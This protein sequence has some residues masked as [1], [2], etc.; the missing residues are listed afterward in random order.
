M[1]LRILVPMLIAAYC[2]VAS[3][4]ANACTRCVYLGPNGTVIV[5]RS[6]D[7]MI[8]PGTNLYMFPRGMQRN[9]AAGANSITWTSK[10]GS[11]VCGFYGVAS[12]DGMNERGL[13]ANTL[14]L[15]ES[16]YGKPNDKRP[17]LSIAAWTQYVLDNYAS[18][19]EA[20][21]GLS[22]EPFTIIAPMLP[23]NVPAQGHLSV[24]DPT[25]DSAI[26]EYVDGKLVIHHGRQYQVMTNSP[27]YNEQL[28]LNTYWK[29][30]GGQNMLP[31]TARAADRFARTSYYIT[32][33][34][35]PKDNA[36]AVAAV[37]SVIRG[38]S[39]PLGITSPGE[40]NVASTI[41]R[42]VYDQNNKIMYF[43]SATS[44]NVFWLPL[45]DFNFQEGA[46]VKMLDLAP[47][48]TYNGDAS[49]HFQTSKPFP[50]LPAV[51][52]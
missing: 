3:L 29:E 49:S 10:Y 23:G 31:G 17:D 48:K 38:A 22:Q 25:G 40:P 9:G 52:N 32:A 34:S 21:Q 43:D 2:G 41:W 8:D 45:A 12:V 18:V 7:W 5:G 24:S 37:F 42:T 15:V 20:V 4:D 13:V 16:D 1:H 50:F 36:D 44:P 35:K 14:Y 39:V 6:M 30:I 47:G 46:E 33:V 26:F 27:T 11:V 51:A 19:N 28:A